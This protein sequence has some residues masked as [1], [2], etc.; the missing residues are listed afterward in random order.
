LE[1]VSRFR[2]IFKNLKTYYSSSSSC[3]SLY[4]ILYLLKRSCALTLAHRHKLTSAKKAFDRWG[5]DLTVTTVTITGKEVFESLRIPSLLGG[6]CF[7][8]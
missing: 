3:S 8:H 5:P 1:V 4:E 7:N 2:K 6:C